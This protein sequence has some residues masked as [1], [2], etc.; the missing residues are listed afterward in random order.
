ML[1]L[2]AVLMSAFRATLTARLMRDEEE[3]GLT[4]VALVWYSAAIGTCFLPIVWVASDEREKVIDYLREKP[5]VGYGVVVA[6]R[7]SAPAHRPAPIMT[8]PPCRMP[9]PGGRG[10]KNGESV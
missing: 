10:G 1:A 3:N 9:Y 6:I 4:P 2:S 7:Q 5:L 8:P